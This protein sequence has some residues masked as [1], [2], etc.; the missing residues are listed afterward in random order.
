VSHGQWRQKQNLARKED[1]LSCDFVVA[2]GGRDLRIDADR[3]ALKQDVIYREHHNF[4]LNAW[5]TLWPAYEG[6]AIGRVLLLRGDNCDY[7]HW[8]L[9]SVESADEAANQA[10]NLTRKEFTEYLDGL[11]NYREIM[12]VVV[13]KTGSFSTPNILEPP[14]VI[15][16]RSDA[17]LGLEQISRKWTMP[18]KNWK[19]ALQ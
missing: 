18:I 10:P 2:N 11:R 14:A 5:R 1:L 8:T 12:N 17:Y 15:R 19:A 13:M 6:Q 4:T 7:D 3:V 16:C 9:G